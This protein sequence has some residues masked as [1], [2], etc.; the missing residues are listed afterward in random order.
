MNAA[1]LSISV[2]AITDIVCAA[3]GVSRDQVTSYRRQ[4]AASEARHI[5]AWIAA[6]LTGKSYSQI[7]R[8]L[9]RDHT[10]IMNSI[11]VVEARRAGDDAY[12]RDLSSLVEVCHAHAET[13]Q[14]GAVPSTPDID[15]VAVASRILETPRGAVRVSVLEI[16]AMA[17]AIIT[18]RALRNA[19]IRTLTADDATASRLALEDVLGHVDTGPNLDEPSANQETTHV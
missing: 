9:G 12:E 6:R 7:G 4:L 19:V 8:I 16:E 5:I 2:R 3:R 10:T 11:R 18:D 13:F 15:A 17:A 1:P 14:R